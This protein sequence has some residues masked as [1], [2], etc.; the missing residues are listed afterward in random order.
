MNLRKK[1]EETVKKKVPGIPIEERVARYLA[2][3]QT[4]AQRRQL[5]KA[6]NREYG[7][8]AAYNGAVRNSKVRKLNALAAKIPAYKVPAWAQEKE[9]THDSSK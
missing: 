6:F 4:F 9:A 3:R 2:G 5:K 7:K 8:A 1:P